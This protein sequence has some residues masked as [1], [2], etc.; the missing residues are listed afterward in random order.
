MK[1]AWK[2]NPKTV[3]GRDSFLTMIFEASAPLLQ[4]VSTLFMLTLTLILNSVW[5]GTFS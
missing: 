3:G 1:C 4:A 5:E 2:I